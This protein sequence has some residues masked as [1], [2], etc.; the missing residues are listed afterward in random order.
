MANQKTKKSV[1]FP[2]EIVDHYIDTIQKDIKIDNVLLFGSFAYGIPSQDSDVDLIVVSKDFK[3]MN[4][5]DRLDW[6]QLKRDKKTFQI[7]LDVIGYTP[8][9]FKMANKLSPTLA[10]AKEHGRYLR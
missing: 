7:S 1:K 6:L 2:K 8:S 10:Y 9:E 5:S 4:F 3:K